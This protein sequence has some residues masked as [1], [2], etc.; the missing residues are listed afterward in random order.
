MGKMK[1]CSECGAMHTNYWNTCPACVRQQKAEDKADQRRAQAAAAEAAR[2]RAEAEAARRAANRKVFDDV[3]KLGSDLEASSNQRLQEAFAELAEPWE[4]QVPALPDTKECPECAEEIKFKAKVCRYCSHKFAG[5]E[6]SIGALEDARAEALRAARKELTQAAIARSTSAVELGLE[7]Y[8]AIHPDSDKANALLLATLEPGGAELLRAQTENLLDGEFVD[9]PSADHHV[10][11]LLALIEDTATVEVSVAAAAS[12]D[13]T[14]WEGILSFAQAGQPL[15]PKM[16]SA[17]SPSTAGENMMLLSPFSA[18]SFSANRPTNAQIET[19]TG[20][21]NDRAVTCQ[22]LVPAGRLE[23]TCMAGKVGQ[24]STTPIPASAQTV[25]FDIEAGAVARIDVQVLGLSMTQFAHNP[26]LAAASKD[27]IKVAVGPPDLERHEDHWSGARLRLAH[28]TYNTNCYAGTEDRDPAK[29]VEALQVI[30]ILHARGVATPPESWSPEVSTVEVSP[31][32]AAGAAAGTTPP[33]VTGALGGFLANAADEA[34]KRSDRMHAEHAVKEAVESAEGP[35]GPTLDGE[36][37]RREELDQAID[38]TKERTALVDGIVEEWEA[39]S[40]VISQARTAVNAA[41]DEVKD[42]AEELADPLEA[43]VARGAIDH[44]AVADA[45][46]LYEEIQDLKSRRAELDNVSGFFAA[47]KAKAEQVA[48]SAQLHLADAKRS[49]VCS[50]AAAALIEADA[51][52]LIPGAEGILARLSKRREALAAAVVGLTNAETARDEQRDGW[53]ER[54]GE[55]LPD[56]GPATLASAA[57]SALSAAES[58]RRAWT[59]KAAEALLAADEAD[60]PP[61][62]HPVRVK[63][64]AWLAAKDASD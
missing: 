4:P 22:F 10:S 27:A 28:N 49:S 26:K 30:S 9:F 44:P 8:K 11:E 58:S 33:T 6:A 25:A 24:Q 53:G 41:E 7:L 59:A 60:W 40:Q 15:V 31:T 16:V 12:N 42:T 34:Q 52:A 43:A 62:G 18:A 64:D 37:A 5:V 1:K 45:A 36:L 39:A 2:I 23:L 54:L 61:E 51:E 19:G 63:L 21:H 32:N 50:K 35:A 48:I 57:R 3:T 46:A 29:A 55:P 38:A 14:G 17:F 56:E 47:A 20:F 13:G